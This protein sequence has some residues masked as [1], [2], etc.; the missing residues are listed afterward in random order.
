MDFLARR[1][2]ASKELIQKLARRFENHELIKDVVEQLQQDGLQSDLAFAESYIRSRAGRGYGSIRITLELG[3]K[4]VSDEDIVQA[5]INTDIDWQQVL[6]Q[7]YQKK[8]SGQPPD[9][10]KEKARY[11][12]F[13]V[14]RGFDQEQIRRLW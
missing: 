10:L 2:H 9:D 7:Q 6:E 4:G 11:T 8:F 14:Y 12:R 13:F 3:Q 5:F 1:D